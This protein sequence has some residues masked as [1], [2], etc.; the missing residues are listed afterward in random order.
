MS[1]NPRDIELVD[2]TGYTIT[3]AEAQAL[4]DAEQALLDAGFSADT[5]PNLFAGIFD[6]DTEE[7]WAAN[8]MSAI[9]AHKATMQRCIEN[10][11]WSWI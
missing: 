5:R 9:A 7:Q 6:D 11:G 1:T 4:I 8:R 3:T 2:P 10:G